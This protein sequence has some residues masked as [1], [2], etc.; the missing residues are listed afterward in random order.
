MKLGSHV[1]MKSPN[2]LVGSVNEAIKD[3]SN[4]FMIYTGAPQSTQRK[5]V[6][7]L[8]IDEFKELLIKNNININ[9]LV[10]HAP[11]VMNLANPD[12]EK[13]SFA[14]DFLTSEILR[15]SNIGIP[16][17]VLHPGAHVQQGSE[18]GIKYII[19]SLNKVLDNTKGINTK[20]ALETMAGKGT[21]VGRNFS[22]LAKIINGV[23]DSDRI[24][25][26]FDT[27]HVFDSGYDIVNNLEGVIDEFDKVIGLDRI[28]CFHINDSKNQLG[29]S[30]DRHENIGYGNIG[31]DTLN[32]IIRHERFKNI[33]KFLETPY[34]SLNDGEKDRT[35]SPYKDEILMI[36]CNK[37]N[38]NLFDDIR[39]HKK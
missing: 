29:S 23:N 2:Y 18:I 25:V 9:D 27:C 33:P 12:T 17:I 7:E 11:Y 4:C 35:L 8:K 3:G 28:T 38:T 32:K 5:S 15:T 14:I 34:V 30:K 31:F 36:K 24:S 37:M 10:V 13:R 39:N 19:D 21:E 26:C 20:I 1:S 22:E 6:D 16:Q